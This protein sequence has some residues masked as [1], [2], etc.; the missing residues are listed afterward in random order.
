MDY[1][2]NNR[3]AIAALY[4]RDKEKKKKQ[5]ERTYITQRYHSNRSYQPTFADALDYMKRK[6]T[7]QTQKTLSATNVN[8][9]KSEEGK[10]LNV[11]TVLQKQKYT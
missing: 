7:A 3:N 9:Q 10:Q 8:T 6:N 4:Q 1:K 2:Q 11:K 5:Q